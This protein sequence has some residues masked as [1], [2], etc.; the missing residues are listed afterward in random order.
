MK[1][2]LFR[3][4]SGDR[5]VGTAYLPDHQSEPLPVLILCHGWGGD[6]TVD[7]FTKALC[8][9]SVE[10]SL[11]VVTF[12][13][14]GSGETGGDFR[15]MTDGRW[16]D[17]LSN[18]CT[19]IST[20]AWADTH[21]I[22][23]LGI[24]TGSTAVLRCAINT[25]Q[26]G[27]GISV[28]TC[29][30]HYIHMPEG[31]GKILIDHFDTLLAGGTMELYGVQFGLDFFKDFIGQS[32]IYHLHEA[33]CPLFFLQGEADNVF[34]RSDARL[35]YEILKSRGLPAHYLEIEQGKHGL[36]NVPQESTSAILA[37][38]HEI[39]ILKLMNRETRKS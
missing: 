17:N 35:G 15:F 5:N 22:G 32:P 10:A 23:A 9:C 1:E 19:Y 29:L 20:Q 26:L 30:G 4:D 18:V 25:S 21:R 3:L 6:R 12:D 24:S 39:G 31:P 27:F 33:K 2:I 36:E 14:Y 13:F 8:Q 16:A 38:L 34:R 7:P 37:W 11:A 28:A